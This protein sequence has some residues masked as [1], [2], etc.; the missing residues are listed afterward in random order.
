M[1]SFLIS[2]AV[3]LASSTMI[4]TLPEKRPSCEEMLI[5][6]MESLSSF[7]I[8]L[9]ILLTIPISSLPMILSVMAYC[10]FPLPLHWAFTTL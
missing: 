3:L 6:R 5:L 1:E 7:E 2:E 10:D 8:M 9:V 4:T